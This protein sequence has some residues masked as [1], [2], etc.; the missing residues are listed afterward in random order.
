MNTGWKV[1]ANG[2]FR[3]CI[4][5]NWVTVFFRDSLKDEEIGWV[6][7]CDGNFSEPFPA[8]VRAQDAAEEEFRGE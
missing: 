1:T 2:N 7:V 5:K 6:Y 4:N 8:R 3:A